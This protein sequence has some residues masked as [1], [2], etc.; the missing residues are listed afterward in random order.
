VWRHIA[1]SAR[2]DSH[3][4]DDSP[5]Q[6]SSRVVVLGG[7]DDHETLVACVTDGAGS[8]RYGAIGSATA[9]D[10]ILHSATAHFEQHGTFAGLVCEDIV[11]WCEA[12][13]ARLADDATS[14]RAEL[15]ELATTLCAAIV[16][17]WC[18]YF[19]QVGDG[20]IILMKNDVSGVVF[21]PQSGEYVNSTNFLTSNEYRDHLQF[22]STTNGFSDVALLTDG[23]ERLAL[24]FDSRTPHRPFFEPL[25]QALRTDENTGDLAEN[26]RR[27]LKSDSV[28]SRSDDDKT[29][30]LAS[31]ICR[32]I[33]H[34]D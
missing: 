2:G 20:A 33:D 23:M 9:A 5:C 18:S 21:W 17:P 13:R 14:R 15:R 31:R 11:R 3:L 29:L 22:A 32:Q 8:A 25:F 12:A 24:R 34:A 4:A 27:F 10:S 7:D 28:R 6:D 16:S 26:L 19:F 30:I 1:E